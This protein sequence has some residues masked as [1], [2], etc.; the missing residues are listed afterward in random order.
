MPRPLRS[1]WNKYFPQ[2]ARSRRSRD[3]RSEF[4]SYLPFL[5]SSFYSCSL[6]FTPC[7]R[8]LYTSAVSGLPAL[9]DSAIPGCIQTQTANLE[10]FRPN[11]LSAKTERIVRHK[12]QTYLNDINTENA[13][14]IIPGS[15][16]P[17]LG[18][19]FE[20]SIST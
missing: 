11:N 3:N 4:A 10:P 15:A 2:P 19:I 14:H 18:G 9:C 1:V 16:R 7:H 17:M 6:P 12:C 13:F 20:R 8:N 5:L